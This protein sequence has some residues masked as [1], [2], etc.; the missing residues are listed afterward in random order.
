MLICQLTNATSMQM[1]GYVIKTDNNK[2]IVIDG[3]GH[4]QA[5]PLK[6]V[7]NGFG[8]HVDMWFITHN[9]SDHFGSIIDL[10]KDNT[11]IVIDGFW[12]NNCK[13]NVVAVMPENEKN[14]VREWTE[15]EKNISVP[16]YN[17]TLNETFNVD[18]V[19]IEVLGVDN[20]EISVNNSNNQ[21]VVLKMTDRNFSI[22]F[23]GDLG[24]EG[25]NK[26]IDTAGDKI[27]S[28]AVQLAHHGNAGVGYNVYEKIG[29]KYAFWPTPKWLWDN[30]EYLGG[31]PGNGNFTTPETI[32]WM[33]KLGCENVTSFYENTFF[34]TQKCEIVF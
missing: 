31:T 12:R 22:I 2:V 20:P 11:E 17:L 34:D 1:M 3:G 33:E 23:L 19:I 28:T 10:L 6:K 13:E 8:N 30:T 21:S 27:K 14:E 5:E 15:F 7:I 4:N 9:H 32:R 18:G 24:V 25:G 26:L 16:L 29:A